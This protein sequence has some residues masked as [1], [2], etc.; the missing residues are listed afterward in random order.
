VS[1][2]IRVEFK[3]GKATVE[4]SGEVPEGTHVIRG[5]VSDHDSTLSVNRLN[6]AGLHQASATSSHVK[7]Q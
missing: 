5:T 1:Y 6:A 3:A 4:V 2:Q 7:E